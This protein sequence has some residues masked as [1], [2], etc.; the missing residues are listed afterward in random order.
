MF[1]I[2]KTNFDKLFGVLPYYSYLSIKL[3]KF[4]LLEALK[5]NV[6]SRGI[7]TQR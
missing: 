7:D 3:V 1:R 6:G 2:G 5:D 4:V